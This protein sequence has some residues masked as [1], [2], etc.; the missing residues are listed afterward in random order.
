[1]ILDLI[2]D[3]HGQGAKLD[4]LL[5][6]LGYTQGRL[7]TWNAPQSERGLVFLGDLIDRGPDQRAVLDRVRALEDSGLAQRIMGNHEMNA[8]H[9]AMERDGAPARA[10]TPAN[11]AH[12]RAF[13]DAFAGDPVGLR[14]A[15]DWMAQAPFALTFDPF[16]CVHAFWTPTLEEDAASLLGPSLRAKGFDHLANSP[17]FLDAAVPTGRAG[18]ALDLMTK[19]PE[20]KLPTGYSIATEHGVVRTALRRTWW[21]DRPQ[22]W[23]EGCASLPDGSVLPDG[24]PPTLDS[25][26]TIP[27]THSV[28]FGHY[29]RRDLLAGLPIPA[30]QGRFACLDQS[31]GAGGDAPLVALT[32]DTN[33]PTLPLEGASTL[34]PRA[35]TI[36]G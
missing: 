16:V 25:L 10:H 32:I 15:L 23:E 5:R 2:P 24:P 1:M 30:F 3:I 29:W 28:I 7:H 19:G 13:L 9:W 33:T 21:S 11:L 26:G 31:A 17:G 22:S 27:S 6:A 18:R 4:A 36:V 34:D 14:H 8:L 12:H 35:L 20:S